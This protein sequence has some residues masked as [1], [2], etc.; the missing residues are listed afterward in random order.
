MRGAGVLGTQEEEAEEL[1]SSFASVFT[2]KL[3]T[4]SS[5]APDLNGRFWDINIVQSRRLRTVKQTGC[6]QVHGVRWD[7]SEGAEKTGWCHC[8][9]MLCQLFMAANCGEQLLSVQEWQVESLAPGHNHVQLQ[10]GN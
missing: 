2:C 6:A 3:C 10:G 5:L 4:Q 7:A 1:S 8:E 9:A